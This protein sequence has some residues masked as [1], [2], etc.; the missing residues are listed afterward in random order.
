V[1]VRVGNRQVRDPSLPG[2]RREYGSIAAP[3]RDRSYIRIGQFMKRICA[4]ILASGSS[5]RLGFN[6]L[7]VKIDGIPVIRRAVSAFL[8]EGIEKVYVATSMEI[9]KMRDELGGLSPVEIVYNENHLE[10][11]SSSVKAVL[12][13][14]GEMDAAFFHLG[15][16]PF[17]GSEQ[18]ISMRDHYLRG[19]GDLM[20]PR[21]NG[22]KGHPVLM[23]LRPYYQEMKGLK[24]DKGL[25]EIIEKHLEDVVFLEGDEGNVFDIDTVEDIETLKRRGHKIEKG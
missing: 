22:A 23:S 25:R 24:G 17:V 3:R 12:P 16:K 20:L 14:L 1:S 11:M 15:D 19:E 9:E 7:T 18:V 2:P 4:V 6:K 13:F 10:G 21:Y 8:V 5:R